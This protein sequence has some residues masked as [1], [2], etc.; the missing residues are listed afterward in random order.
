MPLVKDAA[1][2]NKDRS[3]TDR[4]KKSHILAGKAKD[5]M[6]VRP[7]VAMKVYGIF[8]GDRWL[9]CSQSKEAAK[10]ATTLQLQS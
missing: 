8:D 5:W 1:G 9:L 2:S 3:L 6:V 7:R 10:D 4:T